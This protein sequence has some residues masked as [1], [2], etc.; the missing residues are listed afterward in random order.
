MMFGAIDKRPVFERYWALVG[1]R[2][3]ALR[4]REI[5]DKLVAEQRKA[6]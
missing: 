1:T 6:G 4:A 2:P 3:A 5:D